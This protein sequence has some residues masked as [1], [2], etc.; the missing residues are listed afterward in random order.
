[1]LDLFFHDM[2]AQLMGLLEKC[3]FQLLKFFWSD[4]Y[5]WIILSFNDFNEF[6]SNFCS[7]L[8]LDCY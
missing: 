4:G 7:T 6:L 1:M 2:P 3:F 5:L 8:N